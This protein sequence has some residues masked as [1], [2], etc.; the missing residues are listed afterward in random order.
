MKLHYYVFTAILFMYLRMQELEMK[1]LAEER[2]KEKLE[3]KL[4]RQRVKDQIERDRQ[5]RKEKDRGSQAAAVPDTKPQPVVTTQPPP[6]K[7]YTQ[8][9]IQ[10][11]FLRNLFFYYSRG[12]RFSQ[13]LFVYLN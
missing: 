13:R 5:A 4:A 1:R 7:D 3:D 9:R 2:K 8:T 12:S 6:K 11:L 10:V